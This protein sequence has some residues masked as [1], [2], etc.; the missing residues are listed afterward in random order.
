V[1]VRRPAAAQAAQVGALPFALSA[2]LVKPSK[3]GEPLTAEEIEP[4]DL[5]RAKPH[6][7]TE[8]R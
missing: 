3:P 4:H 8:T 5:L 2:S 1:S 7:H 6:P